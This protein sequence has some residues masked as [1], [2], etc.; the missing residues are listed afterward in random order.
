V[1]C[2]ELVCMKVLDA[3]L[4]FLLRENFTLTTITEDNN[5]RFA[6]RGQL[7]GRFDYF[8]RAAQICIAARVLQTCV[9]L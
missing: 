5:E 9:V 1:P 8:R 2:D 4:L 6:F 3:A 7:S